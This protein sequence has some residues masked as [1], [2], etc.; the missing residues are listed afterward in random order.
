MGAMAMM[1]Q[2]NEAS[3]DPQAGPGLCADIHGE[4]AV[5]R[6]LRLAAKR[7]ID[8]APRFGLSV[9]HAKADR[10]AAVEDEDFGARG[11]GDQ[12]IRMSASLHQRRRHRWVLDPRLLVGIP[13][14]EDEGASFS[15]PAQEAREITQ[16]QTAGT[17]DGKIFGMATFW[18]R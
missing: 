12:L 8:A 6:V 5:Y 9:E 15:L 3:V 2:V 18:L 10:I 17:A 11:D 16:K 14:L 7:N 1:R 13:A 4:F